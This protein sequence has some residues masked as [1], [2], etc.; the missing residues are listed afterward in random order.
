LIVVVGFENINESTTYEITRNRS[1]SVT[2]IIVHDE[3][4]LDRFFFCE[5]IPGLRLDSRH[6]LRPS[7]SLD[8]YSSLLTFNYTVF[9]AD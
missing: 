6:E 5:K 9:V 3:P 4:F 1:L 2:A 8:D 7:I